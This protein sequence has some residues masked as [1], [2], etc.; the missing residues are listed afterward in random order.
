MDRPISIVETIREGLLVEPE[1]APDPGTLK[2][3]LAL[4][5]LRTGGPPID[6]AVLIGVIER[7]R[8]YSVL[9]TL[10]SPDLRSHSGQIAFP[11][12]KVDATDKGAA[13]AAIR[14]AGEEVAMRRD[15][16]E[17]LGYLP[18]FF[19]GT[20]YL[21]TPVVALVQ[22]SAPFVPNPDEVAEVFEVPLDIVA[23]HEN[24]GTHRVAFGGKNHRTW[25]I[26][27][28]G[29]MIW[30]ITAH[31]TRQFSEYALWGNTK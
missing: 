19:T 20:N 2:P 6:A 27:H 4:E 31:L 24:Y 26:D 22:P 15:D 16:V 5:A 10:R 23:G 12:G 17:V 28:E 14:E 9:Y 25:R 21:I 3:D 18:R 8:S 30:G 7:G 1:A 29:R 13:D 11:G